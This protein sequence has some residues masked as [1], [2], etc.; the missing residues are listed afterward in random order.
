MF[1]LVTFENAIVIASN[2]PR[3]WS[4]SQSGPSA[5]CLY[6]AFMSR[7]PSIHP[8]GRLVR[9]SPRRTRRRI[10]TVTRTLPSTR[11][12]GEPVTPRGSGRWCLGRT[13]AHDDGK[14][15]FSVPGRECGPSSPMLREDRGEAVIVGV[16]GADAA[17]SGFRRS[18]AL[19]LLVEPPAH[20]ADQIVR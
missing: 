3:G 11:F 2:I 16:L 5:D 13:L 10:G 14:S 19:L 12:A 20:L 17:I 7:L 15:R 4:T 8:T 1:T 9:T 18:G 6:L